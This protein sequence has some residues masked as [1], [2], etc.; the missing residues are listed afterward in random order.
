M[1]K[2]TDMQNRLMGS[3]DQ[4]AKRDLFKREIPS[5]QE[6]MAAVLLTDLDREDKKESAENMESG[7]RIVSVKLSDIIDHPKQPYRVEDNEEMEE[8]A[9]SIK[10]SGILSPILLTAT[11]GDANLHGK[12]MCVAGHRRRYAAHKAGLTEVPAI[13]RSL[14]EEDADIML[15]S[16]NSQREDTLPSETAKAF[17]I[18]Y[19]ALKK[20]ED[21]ARNDFGQ[22]VQKEKGTYSLDIISKETGVNA[23]KVQRFLRLNE[24]TDAWLKAVD[25]YSLGDKKDTSY[26]AI[27]LTVGVTLSF[28]PKYEQQYVWQC[29]DAHNMNLSLELAEKMKGLSGKLSMDIVDSLFFA[30]KN[31]NKKEKPPTTLKFFSKPLMKKTDEFFP[32]DEIYK[33]PEAREQVMI[34]A[35]AM[36]WDAKGISMHRS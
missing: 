36:Y 8:L 11:Y 21:L 27:G 16:T 13:I 22:V 19:D 2:T 12:Y 24:L 1:S 10:D 31:K 15:V 6:A 25:N 14:S 29:C 23:K 9:Q 28:L 17:K 3:L 20:K 32:D 34:E 30:E 35:L 26:P 7:E 33:S 5:P 18:R 4:S